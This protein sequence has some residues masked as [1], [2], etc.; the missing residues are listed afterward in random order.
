M[1]K[2]AGLT[3][4]NIDKLSIKRL[5]KMKSNTLRQT[6]SLLIKETFHTWALKYHTKTGFDKNTEKRTR[7][8]NSV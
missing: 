4:P 6:E 5:V 3:V 8:D 7:S 2:L 1:I